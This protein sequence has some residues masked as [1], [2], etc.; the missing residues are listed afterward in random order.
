MYLYTMAKSRYLAT[1]ADLRKLAAC[2][3]LL[4]QRLDA[5]LIDDFGAFAGERLVTC[6]SV[7]GILD[8][9]PSGHSVCT[10]FVCSQHDRRPQDSSEM[11]RTLAHLHE[12][13][14]YSYGKYPCFQNKSRFVSP[15]GCS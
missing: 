12:A 7:A 15:N 13:V 5:L 8:W 9:G 3:H 11:M 4:P 6:Q 10:Y 2:L 14:R 1:F